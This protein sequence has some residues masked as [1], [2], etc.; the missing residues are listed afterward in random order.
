MRGVKYIS[1]VCTPH[2]GKCTGLK[3]AE[4]S[5]YW[6]VGTTLKEWG[7]HFNSGALLHVLS[8]DSYVFGIC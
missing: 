4:T 8:L 5:I 1:G 2:V 3:S 7:S 6:I